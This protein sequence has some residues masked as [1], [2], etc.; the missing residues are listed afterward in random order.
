MEDIVARIK[1]IDVEVLDMAHKKECLDVL[2]LEID[3]GYEKIL[4]SSQCLS[5]LANRKLRMLKR[6]YS[7]YR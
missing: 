7:K 4:A 3:K 6:K 2:L 1:N 5:M